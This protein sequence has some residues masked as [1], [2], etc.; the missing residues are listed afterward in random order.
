MSDVILPN[1]YGSKL[2]FKLLNGRNDFQSKVDLGI[3]SFF[4]IPI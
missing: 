4:K 3:P 1:F 2:I